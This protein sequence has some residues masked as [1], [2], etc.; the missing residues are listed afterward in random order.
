MVRSSTNMKLCASVCFD[1]SKKLA[2]SDWSKVGHS[3]RFICFQ[4]KWAR[5]NVPANQKPFGHA[6][7]F[8]DNDGMLSF[9]VRLVLRALW[10]T[11]KNLAT[12]KYR[13]MQ[14]YRYKSHMLMW[15]TIQVTHLKYEIVKLQKFLSKDERSDLSYY[16]SMVVMLETFWKIEYCKKNFGPRK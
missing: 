9:P 1:C 12:S 10:H 13:H 2:K 16:K 7:G 4:S 15:S 5:M 11:F 6:R 14:K 8:S 3:S